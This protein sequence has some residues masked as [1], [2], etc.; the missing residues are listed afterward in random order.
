M[1]VISVSLFSNAQQSNNNLIS[2][3]TVGVD[4][5][6]TLTFLKKSSESY[7]LNYRYNVTKT[8][9]LRFGLNLDLSNG[10][11][12]GYYPDFKIGI[13]K[14]T[15]KGNWNTYY[16]LDGSFYYFKSTANPTRTTRYGVSPFFGVEYYF[17]SHIS[18]ASE[19]SINMYYYNQYNPDS[20][21]PIKNRNYHR[22]VLGSIGMV[23]VM[24]HF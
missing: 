2:K 11:S 3:H 20:F 24:Y 4:I 5:V 22:I 10:E 9:S 14:N 12:D 13:Q 1:I 19:A 17:N 6:N 18:I 16:G 23:M 8:K 21:D 7:L 15:I